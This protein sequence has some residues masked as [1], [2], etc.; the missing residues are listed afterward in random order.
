MDAHTDYASDYVRQCVQTLETTGADNVGGVPVVRPDS[1]RMAVLGA[2]YHSAFAVGGSRCHDAAYEGYVDSVFYG[3][4]RKTTLEEL[5]LFD[6]TL[7]RNQDDELNRRLTK[8]G[9]RIWQSRNIRCWYQPRASVTALFR[10]YFQYGFW[11]VANIFKHGGPAAWR[12][13]VPGTFVLVN[14]ALALALVA[15]GA[16]GFRRLFTFSAALWVTVAGSYAL[17]CLVAAA[18]SVRRRQWWLAFFLPPLFVIYH[19]SYGLGFLMGL[20]YWSTARAG[21]TPIDRPFTRLTR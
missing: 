7:V 10:Q 8:R 3:C 11:R 9:G 17:A 4:W 15:G 5:G 18:F 16:F 12:H 19:V 2:A 13:L 20:I 21:S 6:E 1:L 14:L